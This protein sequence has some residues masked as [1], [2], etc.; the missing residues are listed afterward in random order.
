[1]TAPGKR[2][3]TRAVVY[4]RVS[5]DDQATSI[6]AQ[7]AACVRIAVQHGY[8]IVGEYLDEN[9]SGA[10]AID[11]R[12]ALKS[13]LADLANDQADRLIV[14]K[15]DRL[16]RNVRVAL[17]IEEDY[18]TRHGWGIVFG[19][20]DIDTSTAAGKMQLS[21]FATVAKFER[22][23]IS[24][25]TREALAVKREQG[26]RLGRPSALPDELLSRMFAER[27]AGAS[28]REIADE[29]TRDGI[30]T[31]QGGHSW[32][33][34]TV[35]KALTGQD[36]KSTRAATVFSKTEGGNMYGVWQTGRL[37]SEPGLQPWAVSSS[38]SALE[39]W[40]RTNIPVLGAKRFFFAEKTGSQSQFTD[41]NWTMV[42]HLYKDG[43]KAVRKDPERYIHNRSGPSPSPT[44]V[45]GNYPDPT[46][47]DW[48]RTTVNIDSPGN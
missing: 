24:E 31:A 18:A 1:M 37:F 3:G 9:V 22:D 2:Q 27:A 46:D 39:D 38:L 13:A 32:H 26:V 30:A 28:L 5:T 42:G 35:S 19:D 11:K 43:I 12:P 6:E 8:E 4:L 16:A 25:R 45:H 10:I 20:L 23:R 29:L 7:R 14:A 15:L 33:A 21:M 48:Q 41:A 17:E 47:E 34:S 44:W 40:A 36:G